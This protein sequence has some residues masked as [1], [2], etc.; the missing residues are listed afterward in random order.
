MRL[1]K[2]VLALAAGSCVLLGCGGSSGGDGGSDAI[3]VSFNRNPIVNWVPVRMAGGYSLSVSATLNPVPTTTPYVFVLDSGNVLAP[4]SVTVTANQNGSYSAALPLRSNLV[5]GSYEGN[6]TLKLCR[7]MGCSTPYTL[8]G[9]TL[10]YTLNITPQATTTATALIKVGGVT[11]AIPP[12]L[13]GYGVKHYAISVPTGSTL[14]MQTSMDI[15]SWTFSG[16]GT[17]PTQRYV[18]VTTSGYAGTFSLTV[19]TDTSEA[20]K[21]RGLAADGQEFSFDLTVTP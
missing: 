19:P 9:A 4:G 8:T 1:R 17:L 5:A 12:T 7:D 15:A 14:D 10:P 16:S 18:S 2:A 11:Q 6:F 20:M 13:D 3:H 21:L